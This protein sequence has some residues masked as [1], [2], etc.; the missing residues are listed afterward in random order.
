M[1]DT[2]MGLIQTIIDRIGIP[3]YARDEAISEGLYV[4]AL[5]LRAY[6]PARGAF[7]TYAAYKLNKSLRGFAARELQRRDAEYRAAPPA[8]ARQ[9]IDAALTLEIV[10]D[11]CDTVLTA[12]ERIILLGTAYGLYPAEISAATKVNGAQYKTILAQAR[13][14]VAEHVGID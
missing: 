6:D 12:R 3:D 4:I 7:S 14:I 2:H 9:S 5:A 1:D 10:L 11:A 8:N 13:Q